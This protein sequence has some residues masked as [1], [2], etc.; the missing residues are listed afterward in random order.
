MEISEKEFH[1]G[2]K[3]RIIKFTDDSGSA[4]D[5]YGVDAMFGGYVSNV[6]LEEF[7][8]IIAYDT[9]KMMMVIE[10]RYTSIPLS[11]TI[12]YNMWNELYEHLEKETLVDIKKDFKLANTEYETILDYIELV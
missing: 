12:R 2:D 9:D 3:V 10:N 5:L 7:I 8:G 6:Y 4:S 11:K 1:L